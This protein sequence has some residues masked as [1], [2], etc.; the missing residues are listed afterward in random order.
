MGRARGVKLGPQGRLVVLALFGGMI[1][2]FVLATIS[3]WLLLIVP[4]AIVL[5]VWRQ[6][7]NKRRHRDALLWAGDIDSMTG[8]EFEKMLETVFATLGYKVSRSGQTG[9]FGA[10]LILDGSEGR[11]AVQAK[12]YSSNVG[13]K[14]VQEVYSGM[15]HYGAEKGWVVTNSYFTKAAQTQAKSCGVKLVDRDM[16]MNMIAQARKRIPR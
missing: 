9:D 8:T 13:N 2:I 5:M 4:I 16:L 15:A 10:D 1:L 12:R 14:A 3:P 11:I 6:Q 7:R